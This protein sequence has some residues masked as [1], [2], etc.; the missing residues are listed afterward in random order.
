[1]DEIPSNVKYITNALVYISA[2]MIILRILNIF[3]FN[4]LWCFVPLLCIPVIY[5]LI[6][7]VILLYCIY[8]I[9]KDCLKDARRS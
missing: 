1:M 7:L 5:M 8:K 9:I 3:K 2:I 6:L 4:I